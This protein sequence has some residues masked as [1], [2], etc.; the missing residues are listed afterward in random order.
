MTLFVLQAVRAQSIFEFDYG[1]GSIIEH[2]NTLSHLIQ[3]HPNYYQFSIS[4]P[5]DTTSVWKKRFNYPDQGMSLIVQD[6]K[7]EILGQTIGLNYNTTFYLRKRNKANQLLIDLGLG[8][9]YATN[10]F[11]FTDNNK[12]S[13]I[14][15]S[16]V[17]NQNVA[18][19]YLWQIKDGW[20]LKTGLGFTHFSNASFKQ[21]NNGINSVFLNFGINY[22]RSSDQ[23]TYP[24]PQKPPLPDERKLH[25]G[26]VGKIGFHESYPSLGTQVVYEI[27]PYLSKQIK[28]LGHLNMGLDLINSQADKTYADYLYISKIEHPDRILEEHKRV[29][30]YLGYEQFFNKISCEADLGYYLYKK[31]DVYTDVYQNIKIKYHFKS[32]KIRVGLGLKLHLFRANYSTFEIQYQW[33]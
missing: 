21:P 14:S 26:M 6:F 18:I 12:N 8:L 16:I 29:G 27:S 24:E 7:N 31:L 9:A 11:D 2:K 20:A 28:P 22:N 17:Y 4:K 33:F 15:T 23:F 30:L 13:V 19:N 10:H 25:F 32:S 1:I 5:S 3:A